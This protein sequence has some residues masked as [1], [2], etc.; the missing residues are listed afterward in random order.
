MTS[1]KTAEGALTLVSRCCRLEAEENEAQ[2][3]SEKEKVHIKGLS[4]TE[5]TEQSVSWPIA[6]YRLPKSSQ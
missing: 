6:R 5:I 2:S 1:N 3:G 4:H